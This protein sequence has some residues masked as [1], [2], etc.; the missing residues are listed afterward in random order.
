MSIAKVTELTASSSKSFEDAI[1]QGISR[2]GKTVRNIQS[3]WVNEQTVVV[4]NDKVSEWRVNLRIT[5]LL[6]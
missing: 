1:Q 3:A 6:D 2:A 4:K 5:F